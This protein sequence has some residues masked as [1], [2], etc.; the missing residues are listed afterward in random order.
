MFPVS[1]GAVVV[2]LVGFQTS[3]RQLSGWSV[4]RLQERLG[5]QPT[6]TDIVLLTYDDV[7]RNQAGAADLLDQPQLM[8]LGQWASVP[9]G[10]RC[11]VAFGGVG[12]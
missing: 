1:L 6:P 10:W 4:D 9:Y 7:T 2:L 11:P 8:E 3:L 5:V 12:R